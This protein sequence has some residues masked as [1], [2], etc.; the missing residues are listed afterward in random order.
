MNLAQI[1]RRVSVLE[2]AAGLDGDRT[3][4]PYKIIICAGSEPTPAERAEAAPFQPRALFVTFHG[5]EDRIDS[6]YKESIASRPRIDAEEL[7]HRAHDLV[8]RSPIK[9]N[10]EIRNPITQPWAKRRTSVLA[11]MKRAKL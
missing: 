8:E 2:R 7:E 10:P 9:Q 6:G 1:D 5:P 3:G 4:T 11:V